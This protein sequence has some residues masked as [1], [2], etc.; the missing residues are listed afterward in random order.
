MRIIQRSIFFICAVFLITCLSIP[1]LAQEKNYR[2]EVLQITNF[3]ELQ[4]VYDGFLRELEKSG[5]SQGR[6]LTVNRTMIEIGRAS[7]RERV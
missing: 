7:C 1:G 4:M 3:E 6:N 5:I 2:V